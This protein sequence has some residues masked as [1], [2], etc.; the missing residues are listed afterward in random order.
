[1]NMSE[2]PKGSPAGRVSGRDTADALAAVLR[3]QKE[4]AQSRLDSPSKRKK[5][6]TSPATW[7]AFVV[8]AALSGY[9]WFVSPPWLYTAPPS[10][11]PALSDAGL[12]M[13][14]LG[15]A[16]LI[17]EFREAEGRL[18]N[19]LS[20]AGDP[21]SE[22]EYD[23]IDARDYRLRFSG[24]GGEVEYFSTESLDLFLGNSLQ[25]IRQGG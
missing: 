17:E 19:D 16:L 14:V 2:N 25:V 23:R 3:D 12:R 1:M 13:E 8:F 4:K 10:P 20:E 21:F 24:R 6:K 22:V 11:S 9:I 15:Q 7:V 5:R 18:P